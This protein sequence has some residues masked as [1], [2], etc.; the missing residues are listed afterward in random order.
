MIK[1]LKDT[2]FRWP[3]KPPNA[4][5]VKFN[6]VHIAGRGSVV[7]QLRILASQFRVLRTGTLFVIRNDNLQVTVVVNSKTANC[8]NKTNHQKR[9]FMQVLII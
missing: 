7:N 2:G 4:S 9:Q 8:Y 3:Q 5:E 6:N 1:C